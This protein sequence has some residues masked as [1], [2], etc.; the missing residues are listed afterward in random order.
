MIRELISLSLIG[1]A[2]GLLLLYVIAPG[3]SPP[4]VANGQIA[5]GGV[6]CGAEPA[7]FEELRRATSE[8]L[9]RQGALPLVSAGTVQACPR[10]MEEADR[11][12]PKAGLV[13]V[14][15]EDAA[16]LHEVCGSKQALGC[17]RYGGRVVFLTGLYQAYCATA[18][19]HEI[20]HCFGQMH[21]SDRRNVMFPYADLFSS[22]LS[23][24]YLRALRE[25]PAEGADR[26]QSCNV[27]E[28][29]TE[30]GVE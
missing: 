7:L 5:V 12:L 26:T 19:A 4:R 6:L 20:G 23:P 9:V 17:A 10:S 24:S 21:S 3:I 25:G 15:V 2:L 28:A 27:P 18:F 11:L 30:G 13:L 8:G 29:R 16:F 22:R 1:A 14:A